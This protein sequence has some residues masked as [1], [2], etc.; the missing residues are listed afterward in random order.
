M[1]TRGF[2]D[3]LQFVL[4]WEGG[5]V[6][7]PADPGGRTN[8]GVTQKTY[9][10]WRGR[11]GLARRD[12]LDIEEAEVEEIYRTDYW[13]PAGCGR[14]DRPLDIVVFD[15][16]VN[17]GIR[18]AVRIL[19]TALGCPVDGRFGP[20]TAATA[21]A[22]ER[23][24]T[25]ASY[26]RIREGIYRGLVRRN[27]K[28]GRFLKGWLNRLD[29]VRRAAGLDGPG[30]ARGEARGGRAPIARVADLAQDQALEEWR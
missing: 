15:T 12:V 16:A 30:P 8:R 4:R 20:V 18:R 21:A 27:P 6:E 17:M 5:F 28:L 9:D 19:Q 22:C 25:A 29:S 7:D 14:L 23:D 2:A 10:A 3:A 26:C 1:T 13:L 11:Q 24:E